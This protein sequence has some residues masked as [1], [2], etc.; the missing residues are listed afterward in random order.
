MEEIVLKTIVKQPTHLD[1]LSILNVRC[2]TLF[3]EHERLF[4][5][6][7]SG[8]MGEQE[9]I[10]YFKEYGGRH[11]RFI[12]NV[13]ANVNGRF[14]SDLIIITRAYIYVLEVKNYTGIFKY[15][16][17]ISTIDGVDVNADCI[18][19]ARRSFKNI[20]KLLAPLVGFQQVKGALIFSGEHNEVHIRSR[21]ED[22]EIV[23][24]NQLLRFIH[25]IAEEEDAHYYDEIAITPIIKKLEQVQLANPFTADPLTSEQMKHVRSGIVCAH[26]SNF[27]IEITRKYVNCTC[28]CV[29]L[30][31]EAMVRTICEYGMLRYNEPLRRNELAHFFGKQASL[32]YL[33]H[34]LATHFTMEGKGKNTSYL[35]PARIASN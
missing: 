15:D 11:W 25:K 7:R 4:H 23:Q 31:E 27:N 35:N 3:V 28:G 20:Q 34:I 24:R 19:Q 1:L 12:R 26:C 32:R 17:G 33:N 9:V 22:I 29:E 5:S 2:P 18:F 30:R 6:L 13:W 14:E 10:R 16:E 8:E 21:V